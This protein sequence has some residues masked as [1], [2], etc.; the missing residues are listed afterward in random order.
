[1]ILE[2]Y[3]YT[4][5]EVVNKA[6][7]ALATF[8]RTNTFGDYLQMCMMLGLIT[9]LFIFMLSRNP[10]DLIKWMVVFFAVPL[11]LINMKADMLIIDK[12]QPGKA[13]KVDNVPYL[14]AV[15]TYFFS[16]IMV[17]MAEGVEG[18]F[19]TSDDERYGRTGM[20]FG[21]ELYQLSRQSRINELALQK[22]WRDYFHNCMIGDV[23]INGK[24]TWDELFTAPDIFAFLDGVRQSPLRALYLDE[25][26]GRS[27]YKRCEEAYPIIKQ[28]FDDAANKNMSLLAHQLL[29]K[30]ADR[31]K[32][33]VVQSLTRSYDKFFRMST[34][35]SSTIKQNMLMNELR[36]NLDSLDPTQAALNYAYTTNKLQTTS[37][38]A[39][40]G[41]MAREYLPMLHTMM[42]MLFACLGFFVAGAAVIPGLTMMVLKN[43]FG[44]FAFLATWPALFAIING[45]QLWG[46]ESLSTDVSGKFGGLVLSN[47]NAADELHSRFAWITGILMIG[48]P[49]IAK[50]ILKG[51]QEV[52]SSMNYQLSSMINSTNA[53]ASAAAST[54]N[55][56]FGSMQIDNHSMNNTHANKFDTN[57]LANQGH[58][59]TQNPDG[60][61][62][63][64]HGDGRTTYDSSQTTSRG[65]I[66]ANTQSMLQESVANARNQ[67]QQNLE[68][69]ST[70][71]SQTL[72]GGAALSDRWHDSVGKNLAYG[73][74]STSGFNTQVSQGMNDMQTAV[75]SV[76][77]QTGWT[78]DQS[79]AYLQSVYG[80]FEG[81]VGTG[82]GA[83]PFNLGAS[84][85]V[86]WSD[87]ER[88]A[89]SK[90]NTE[91]KQQLEQATQQ[92]TEGAN[93]V[94]S[95]GT[96]VDNKDTRTSVEQFAHDFAINA[97]N[98]KSLGVSAMQ[99]QSDLNAL[100]NTQT[101]LDSGSASFTANAIQ[102]F[103]NYLE[104]DIG[105]NQPDVQRL[106]TAYQPEDIADAKKSWQEYTR[107]EEFTTMAGLDGDTAKIVATMEKAHETTTPTQQPE[108]TPEQNNTM[109][110]GWASTVDT[111]AHTRTEMLHT[112]G[113][114]G[115]FNQARFDGVTDDVK[116]QQEEAQKPIIKPEP[117]IELTV[118]SQVEKEITRPER[119]EYVTSD[120]AYPAVPRYTQNSK[121]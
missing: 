56:D 60:S 6:F 99:S 42:F 97:S 36:Y 77:Q 45:F 51:G 12:T 64:Q 13:Y 87:D 44:T 103:Q 120:Q 26:G 78:K 37:M 31:Y 116:L 62:T 34:S 88:T 7:N 35:A 111:V 20:L 55:L 89:Y 98:T 48:V 81:G 73:E 96:Q 11:F 102:G 91:Q 52:M 105:L 114:G 84:G 70:Q 68:Q 118:K 82:K 58:S 71:L 119:T 3:T 53:R 74:G 9:S 28:R 50:G 94:T 5:G 32:P 59:Y 76:I 69:T 112:K 79:Q 85:G 33:Q 83:S 67:T 92:Y 106:M 19:T 54:G 21:S 47:A 90:M 107:T 110:K 43:Y 2:Y 24:Y 15:P 10:K 113:T 61:V 115:L 46:L 18:I 4:S 108:L 16:S 14:V 66:S 72:Q 80:G 75:D 109:E 117:M 23:R 49:M 1:M 41:L 57:T 95:A 63:T 86:K 40:L 65:N 17:G 38:W 27:T 8:F 121:E 93:A 22:L 29:G 30:D 39:S 101:R 25:G 104:K 100:S